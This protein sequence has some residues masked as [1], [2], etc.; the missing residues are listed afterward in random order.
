MGVLLKFPRII[1]SHTPKTLPT[2]HQ[3]KK[4]QLRFFFLSFF[5]SQL[6]TPQAL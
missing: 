6:K 2:I 3:Q 5:L 4:A 1:I